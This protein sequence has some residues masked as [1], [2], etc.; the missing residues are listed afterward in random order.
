MIHT[1]NFSYLKVAVVSKKLFLIRSMLKE[2]IEPCVDLIVNCHE[3]YHPMMICL[4]FNKKLYSELIRRKIQSVIDEGLSIV[5]LDLTS[6][7]IVGVCL[8]CDALTQDNGECDD[9]LQQYPEYRYYQ[10]LMGVFS[11]KYPKYFSPETRGIS[12]IPFNLTIEQKYQSFGLAT[13]I[14]KVIVDEHPKYCRYS[15]LLTNAMSDH[16]VKFCYNLCKIQNYRVFHVIDAIESEKWKSSDGKRPFSN[17]KYEL[18][19]RGLEPEHI[20]YKF[21]LWERAPIKP[22]L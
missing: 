7:K 21:I 11:K 3:S 17:I 1:N 13:E 9:I 16:A 8:G 22:K 20:F 10:E 6:K 4:N 5:C 2:D 15:Y 19:K 12:C 18:T 14:L